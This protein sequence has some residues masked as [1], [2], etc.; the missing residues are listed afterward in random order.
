MSQADS[1]RPLT[2]E[3]WVRSQVSPSEIC[4]A[5]SGIVTGFS[6]STSVFPC[7]YHS[8]SGSYSSIYVTDA[9]WCYQLT[10]TYLA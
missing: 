2:A 4:G 6:P 3:V 9:V 1:C 8:T 5:Q 7:Q 10:G